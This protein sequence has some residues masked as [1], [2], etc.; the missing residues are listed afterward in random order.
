M[1]VSVDPESN[2]DLWVL[3]MQ[4]DPTPWPFLKTP[5]RESYG[6]FSPDGRWVAYHSH[7]S[8][9]PEVYVRPFVPPGSSQ[10]AAAA[11]PI[12]TGG[13]T[14]PAWALDGRELYYLNPAGAMMAASITV[15]GD[16]LV[17]GVP[18]MLFATRISGGGEDVQQGRQYDVAADGRFLIHTELDDDVGSPITL[19]Q[20]WDPTN[21][22]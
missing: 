7:E 2:G 9:R 14:F 3:P 20:N 10:P 21:P 18:E 13:G 15:E 11:Q 8:G 22:E 19:I 4:G 6:V 12:S 17:P 5:F 1:Y 16:V